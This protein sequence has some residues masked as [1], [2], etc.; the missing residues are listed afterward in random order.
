V[1]VTSVNPSSLRVSWQPPLDNNGII[2]G[3]LIEY[4]MAGSNNTIT[5]S[6][7]TGNVLQLSELVPFVDYLVRV[8]ARSTNG[9]GPFSN[10]V[11]QI[12][13]QASKLYI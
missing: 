3:Y 5:E 8:A 6:I 7:L 9:V 13:G 11:V 2:T 10:A 12:S 4:T 1:I